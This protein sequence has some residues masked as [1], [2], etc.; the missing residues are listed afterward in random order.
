ALHAADLVL[1][2]LN[3]EISTYASLRQLL[4]NTAAT[5]DRRYFVLNQVD[6]TR[7]LQ[8]D[9][10]TVLRSDLGTALSEQVIHRDIAVAEAAASNCAVTVHA[11]HSQAAHDFQ[12]LAGWLLSLAHSDS[13]RRG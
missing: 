11:A 9:I 13:A 7:A 4:D 1:G 6:A 12:G 5:R 3:A 10:M 2:V 8:N